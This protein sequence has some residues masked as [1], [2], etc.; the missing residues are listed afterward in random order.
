[1][2]TAPLHIHG[3]TAA[4]EGYQATRVPAV[5][6]TDC[7]EYL[8]FPQQEVIV[9]SKGSRFYG[10]TGYIDTRRAG[11]PNRYS[12]KF[13]GTTA[14]TPTY[15]FKETELKSL[16]FLPAPADLWSGKDR[17]TCAWGVY[18]L[19][20]HPDIPRRWLEHQKRVARKC[21]PHEV[22]CLHRWTQCTAHEA[23][24]PLLKAKVRQDY[25][26]HIEMRLAD[27]AQERRAA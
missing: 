2:T 17:F 23:A 12:V 9:I 7:E 1:M 5:T 26:A 3:W 21:I 8:F 25:I 11:R 20:E 22:I 15:P 27:V 24:A 4:R 13:A 18:K 19:S 14:L 6:Y 16:C 10:M